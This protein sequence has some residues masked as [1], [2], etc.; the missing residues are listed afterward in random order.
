MIAVP[1]ETN[2]VPA[3]SHVVIGAGVIGLS[4][5]YRLARHFD[6]VLLIDRED[7]GMA[8]S[9]GNAGHIATEQVFPLPSPA[10]LRNAPRLLLGRNGPLS[11]RGAY[12]RK[13][14]PWLLRFAW[15]SRPAAFA[16]GT[17]AL[18]DLQGRALDAL[19]ALCVDADVTNQLHERGHLILV[20]NP[21]LA[22]AAQQ[23]LNTLRQHDISADWVPAPGVAELAPGLVGNVG[24]I[25]VRDSAHVGD[26]L[27]VS[28][29]LLK[30]FLNAGG[31]L[32]RD[33]VAGIELGAGGDAA[34]LR[35]SDG[36][37]QAQR[38]VLAAGAWSGPLAAQTGYTLPLDTERGYHVQLPS[39][40]SDLEVAVASLDRMTIMT[41]LQSGLRI[42]GFVELGGLDLPPEPRRLATLNQHLNELLPAAPPAPRREWMGFRPS[43]PDH[44]PVL[45]V[46]P[47]DPRV[48]YAFG[49]QHLG[50]TLAGVTADIMLAL[51]TGKDPGI[52]LTPFRIDRF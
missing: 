46:H 19:R 8:A 7:P 29:G 1:S 10:T 40:T 15:A 18:S 52:D 26:P 24:A 2:S 3:A 27:T 25:Y 32:L 11:L 16:R 13:I 37:L 33:E 30:A 4:I 44:L 43:L 49:H 47:Q 35:L 34:T 21:R 51:A 22:D 17:A 9:Y 28:R 39:W 45:G 12:V 31:R 41:P 36:R 38:V 48:L 6:N 20:E 5:A 50:L 14:V 23:Q 42:T